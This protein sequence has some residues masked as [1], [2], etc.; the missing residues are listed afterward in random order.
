M[1]LP[2]IEAQQWPESQSAPGRRRS[3]LFCGLDAVSDMV[4]WRTCIQ[5]FSTL[6]LRAGGWLG[7]CSQSLL[8]ALVAIEV[9]STTT[10]THFARFHTETTC[11]MW[12]IARAPCSRKAEPWRQL[13]TQLTATSQLGGYDLS[14]QTGSMANMAHGSVLA[15]YVAW[16]CMV[17]SAV[18]VLAESTLGI[19]PLQA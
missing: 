3:C 10:R 2:P 5:L 6:L 18:G 9:H 15:R 8:L 13:S 14:F 16:S 12:R 11:A 7:H 17:M 19:A 1:Q 4:L